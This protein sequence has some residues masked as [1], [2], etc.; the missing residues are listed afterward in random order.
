MV[1]A[2]FTDKKW[3]EIHQRQ[4][5]KSAS[6]DGV[7]TDDIDKI[8]TPPPESDS[9]QPTP[10]AV[11]PKNLTPAQVHS[12]KSAA[13]PSMSRTIVSLPKFKTVSKTATPPP[14]QQP[15]SNSIH[16]TLASSVAA[17][18]N[19]PSSNPPAPAIRVKAIESMKET[20]PPTAVNAANKANAPNNANPVK[21]VNG[22]KPFRMPAIPMSIT[23][24]SGLDTAKTQSAAG[25]RTMEN[26]V[27][28]WNKVN[29]KTP[30]KPIEILVISNGSQTNKDKS[31]I[32]LKPT[33]ENNI[34]N[35]TNNSS[36]LKIGQVYE[37]VSDAFVED[38]LDERNT[39]KA[40]PSPLLDTLVEEI[41]QTPTRAKQTEC[42]QDANSNQMDAENSDFNNVRIVY[43]ENETC[44]DYRCNIC[45][46]FNKSFPEFKAHMFR[47]HKY[48][49][50][51]QT[52][53][54]SFIT[55]DEYFHHMERAVC[56][57]PPN[58]KRQFVCI[59]DPPTV[60]MRNDTVFA[61]RCKH[62]D[63]AFRNQRN[64][65]QHAQRH[66]KTFRCKRCPKSGALHLKQMQQHL[67]K[68]EETDCLSFH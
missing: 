18:L 54:E 2:L 48:A 30:T 14:P 19:E 47:T 25:Q 9:I 67:K 31:V 12:V 7:P 51:C 1:I 10:T 44:F 43:E 28:L 21:I 62:C 26:G 37:C 22:L 3:S 27:R 64:Y 61:F 34:E 11:Q 17:A 20:N 68:H 53:H 33:E 46:Q 45:L 36:S 56:R 35:A 24:K 66:A 49:L 29:E 57:N 39:Q 5:S 23:V 41:V 8:P 60:L 59:V 13:A 50:T 16:K 6:S 15:A 52:C 42:I 4:N 32:C 55:R 63:I 58:S 65:V 38:L 40:S